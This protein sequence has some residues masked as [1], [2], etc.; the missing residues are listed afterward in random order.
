MHNSSESDN[1]MSKR[2]STSLSLVG[3]LVLF[4]TLALAQSGGSVSE[5]DKDKNKEHHSRFA[6]V[7]F[8]HHRKS[9]HKNATGTAKKAKSAQPQPQAAQVKPASFKHPTKRDQERQQHASKVSKARTQKASRHSAAK[10]TIA[11][12][13]HTSI[14]HGSA[15]SHPAAKK[16]KPS[17]KAQDRTTASLEQ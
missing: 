6:K 4:S 7:E 12:R 17:Q 10:F 9:G 3:S 15:K 13:K 1:F 2:I 11:A 14:A 8:W 16:A 5:K